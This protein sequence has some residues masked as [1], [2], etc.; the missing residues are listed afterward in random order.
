MQKLLAT[1]KVPEMLKIDRFL[2]EERIRLE[3]AVNNEA[4]IVFPPTLGK[5]PGNLCRYYRHPRRNCG[6]ARRYVQ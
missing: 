2:G 1:Q 6:A 4:L 5:D 3:R